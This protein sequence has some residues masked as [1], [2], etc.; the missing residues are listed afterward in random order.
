MRNISRYSKLKTRLSLADGL[1]NPVE[2]AAAFV[3]VL[4]N[5][6]DDCGVEESNVIAVIKAMPKCTYHKDDCEV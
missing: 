4:G 6:A 2:E 3:D 1:W 5:F